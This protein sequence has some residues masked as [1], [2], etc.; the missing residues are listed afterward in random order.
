MTVTVSFLS[1][2]FNHVASFLET[3]QGVLIAGWDA[4]SLPDFSWLS[5]QTT[6]LTSLPSLAL[7]PYRVGWLQVPESATPAM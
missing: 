5:F 3:L 4:G 7:L 1:C 6:L 2:K